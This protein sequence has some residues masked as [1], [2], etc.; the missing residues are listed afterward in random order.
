VVNGG[1]VGL[2]LYLG[3][4]LTLLRGQLQAT[5]RARD[6]LVRYLGLAGGLA[7]IGFVAGSLGPSTAIHFAPMWITFGLCMITMVLARREEEGRL[8]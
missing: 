4:Y 7:L 8:R 5:R 6:G 1:L 3:F 2:A